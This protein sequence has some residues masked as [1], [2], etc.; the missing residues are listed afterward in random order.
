MSS[1]YI[2]RVAPTPTGYLHRGHGQTFI[3]A[4]KRA[5]KRGG[6]LLYRD[7]DL[8]PQR[9]R[10]E[11][12]EA[13]LE[14]IRWLG[15]EWDQGPD[16][17]G[18]RG[19]FRQSERKKHYLKAWE[20]LKASGFIYP[21]TRSRKELT[22]AAQAGLAQYAPPDEDEQDGEPIFPPAW[23]PEPGAGLEADEPGNMNWRMRVPDG[24]AVKFVDGYFGARSYVAGRDFGDFLIWRRD[25]IPSYELAVVVDDIEMGV[26]EVVRGA[27]LLRST[28]RQLLIYLALQTKPPAFFH[29]PLVR[30][31]AGNRLA[32][33]S[34]SEALRSFREK[35]F[36]P[37]E[38]YA[39]KRPEES[40]PQVTET[41]SEA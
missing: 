33:R 18:P 12:S 41:A 40:S 20:K 13:A 31:S 15:I 39:R 28:A 30:D 19:P 17:G 37:K 16:I 3:V 10:P 6:E 21:T 35:G 34:E 25:G 11:F 38:I 22:N 1:P 7:E 23:R 24:L 32:K 4:W 5:Q 36:T 2:G 9:C 14:D 8:D 29:C 26:T 27:D